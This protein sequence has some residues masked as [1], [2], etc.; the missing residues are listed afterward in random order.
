MGEGSALLDETPSSTRP[1]LQAQQDL[2]CAGHREL[3]ME[4]KGEVDASTQP[5]LERGRTPS[6]GRARTVLP[7]PHERRT[8][9]F[10]FDQ[11]WS[12][13]T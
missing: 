9:T 1:Q 7:T 4:A 6:Q 8:L 13:G 12:V 10:R 5:G 2:R 3:L 11:K